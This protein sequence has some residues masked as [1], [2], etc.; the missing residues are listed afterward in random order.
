M[1]KSFLPT[2]RFTLTQKTDEKPDRH[3]FQTFQLFKIILPD[4]KTS[5]LFIVSK[6]F[7]PGGPHI[8]LLPFVKQLCSVMRSVF[9][10]HMNGVSAYAN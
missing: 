9:V 3:T 7:R 5:S 2:K 6:Y 4:T 1:Q 10:I 8:R